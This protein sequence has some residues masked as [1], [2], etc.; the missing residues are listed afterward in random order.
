[1]RSPQG[2]PLRQRHF[3]RQI[4]RFRLQVATAIGFH[5]RPQAMVT[6]PAQM[7]APYF[8]LHLAKGLAAG[9]QRRKMFMGSASATVFQHEAVMFKEQTMGL[10]FADPAAMKGHD[11]AGALGDR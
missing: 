4:E 5:F 7:H 11:F 3:A 1:M 8:P 2:F 10:E 6:A 9:N